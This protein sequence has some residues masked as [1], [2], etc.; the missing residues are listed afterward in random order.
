MTET[1]LH[2]LKN[3][4]ETNNYPTS[5]LDNFSSLLHGIYI[6]AAEQNALSLF[7]S[8]EDKAL[9]PNN[10][11]LQSLFAYGDIISGARLV[12]IGHIPSKHDTN[13]PPTKKLAAL[14]KQFRE[15]PEKLNFTAIE[16]FLEMMSVCA[17]IQ[18]TGGGSESWY[19]YIY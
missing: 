10:G 19:T 1:N 2:L 7:T 8:N 9:L 11:D 4:V 16:L 6:M 5:F 15:L 18:H 17:S 12:S 13:K 3:L 14:G